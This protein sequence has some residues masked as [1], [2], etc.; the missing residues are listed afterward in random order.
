MTYI[1]K[2][3]ENQ[4]IL[5]QK[6]RFNLSEQIRSC[7]LLL[8]RK[9]NEKHLDLSLD[10][11]EYEI[12]AEQEMLKQ[13]W[14]NLLDNAVKFTPEYGLI[15]V[16]IQQQAEQLIVSVMNTGSTIPLAPSCMQKTQKHGTNAYK[17]PSRNIRSDT[18]NCP[19]RLHVM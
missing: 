5:G 17:R 13:V 12:R 14:I 3:I 2:F 10:F 19:V 11:D 8:E 9:W 7:I 16:S 6:T 4:A 18:M 1:D 15:R